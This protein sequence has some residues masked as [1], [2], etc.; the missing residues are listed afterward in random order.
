MRHSPVSAVAV[1][2]GCKQP[3]GLAGDF[4]ALGPAARSADS[5]QP[6]YLGCAD[7]RG[8]AK[9]GGSAAWRA[10][11][12]AAGPFRPPCAPREAHRSLSAR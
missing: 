1:P 11:R 4:V 2:T 9:A 7:L 8:G 10:L 3:V 5:Q 12:G 6:T